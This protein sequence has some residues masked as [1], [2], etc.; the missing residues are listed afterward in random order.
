MAEDYADEQFEK[1]VASATSAGGE[2]ED[3]VYGAEG[4]DWVYEVKGG[5]ITAIKDGQRFPVKGGIVA[6]AI[7][8]QLRDGTLSQVGPAQGDTTSADEVEI[9]MDYMSGGNDIGLR[10]SRDKPEDADLGEA[11]R[12]AKSKNHMAKLREGAA[13]RALSGADK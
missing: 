8:G 7:Q 5:E 4:D 9:N 6:K 3:G 11:L 2:F 10:D 1:D 13:E 12:Y